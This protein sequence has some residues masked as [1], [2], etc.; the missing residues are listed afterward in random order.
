MWDLAEQRVRFY[1]VENKAIDHHK[2]FL[3][4]IEFYKKFGLD[5]MQEREF[6]LN[7]SLPIEGT[8]LE[9]GTG[10]G[11]FALALAQ[12][13]Y[14]FTTVDI[15]KEEQEI[16]RLNFRHFNLDH[17]VNFKIDDA[18]HLSFPDKSFDVIFC[19]NVYHHL[20]T[21]VQILSEMLRVLKPKGKI[22][23]S[24]FSK[25]GMDIIK[26]CHETEGRTHDHFIN[27]LETARQFFS[28]REFRIQQENS[29]VQELIIARRGQAL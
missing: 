15:D 16:T 5:Q 20:K 3:E 22:V 1:I 11:H 12:S 19:I 9:I 13:G 23:L 4:R 7:K 17:L 27:N 6:I 26:K 21:P 8:I 28:D 14:R 18:R 29:V 24:D 2:K 25:A 10:K